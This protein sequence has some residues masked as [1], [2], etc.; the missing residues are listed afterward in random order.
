[1]GLERPSL[2]RD[3]G[4]TRHLE[5]RTTPPALECW[6]P[7][8]LGRRPAPSSRC[9]TLLLSTWTIGRPSKSSERRWRAW[10][11]ASSGSRSASSTGTRE[12]PSGPPGV[13]NGLRRRTPVPGVERSPPAARAP[14]P[15]CGTEP[16]EFRSTAGVRVTLQGKTGRT[17]PRLSRPST[18]AQQLGTTRVGYVEDPSLTGRKREVRG[19]ESRKVH[20]L[21]YH[22]ESGLNEG[23]KAV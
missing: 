20:G 1:M 7:L 8:N 4:C 12:R 19:R 15:S 10:R 21:N 18:T 6:P 14:P 3:V 11:P 22:R 9:G 2:V 5:A 23:E 13:R 17:S 16:P